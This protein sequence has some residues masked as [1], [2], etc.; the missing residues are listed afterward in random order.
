M[1]FYYIYNL[2]KKN[3]YEKINLPNNVFY[4]NFLF[5]KCVY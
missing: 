3:K 4:Y 2:T 1:F 5:A